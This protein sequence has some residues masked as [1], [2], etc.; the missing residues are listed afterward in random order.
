MLCL[1]IVFLEG[2]IYTTPLFVHFGRTLC[3]IGSLH[4]YG[5]VHLTLELWFA[6]EVAH[7]STTEITTRRDHSILIVSVFQIILHASTTSFLYIILSTFDTLV[8]LMSLCL[9]YIRIEF[10]ITPSILYPRILFRYFQE[11]ILHRHPNILWE[12]QITIWL[13]LVL[14]TDLNTLNLVLFLLWSVHHM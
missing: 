4:L 1:R 2:V 6:A 8:M 12:L 13:K 7:G 14:I 11:I 3:L 10:C 9:R 5:S